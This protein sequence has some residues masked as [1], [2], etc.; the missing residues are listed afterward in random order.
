M[1]DGRGS[2]LR[3]RRSIEFTVKQNGG[4][5]PF[6]GLMYVTLGIQHELAFVKMRVAL[7]TFEFSSP[8]FSR[9]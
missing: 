6:S 7:T 3:M 2:T 5:L 9:L 8:S 4:L 1:R